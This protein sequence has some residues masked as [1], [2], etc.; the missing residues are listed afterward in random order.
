MAALGTLTVRL[1]RYTVA[2]WL[3]LE[4]EAGVRSTGELGD[5]MVVALL[6]AA[7]FTVLIMIMDGVVDEPGPQQV[8]MVLAVPGAVLLTVP[9]SD[10]L[11]LPFEVSGWWGVVLAS[12]AVTVLAFQ[13]GRVPQTMLNGYPV[14]PP[15]T[16]FGWFALA[17]A[18]LWL[19]QAVLGGVRLPGTVGEQ[20][21]TLAV[22]AGLFR[23]GGG[24]VVYFTNAYGLW[25]IVPSVVT[26]FVVCGLKL[27]A[28]CWL[29]TWM[30]ATLRITGL[31][32]FALATLMVTVVTA[33]AWWYEQV[34]REEAMIEEQYQQQLAQQQA[35]RATTT[36]ALDAARTASRLAEEK[37]RRQW[38]G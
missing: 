29:S 37:R 3:V 38:Y 16:L 7:V 4:A 26:P 34:S 36:W 1:L 2:V 20:L 18:G 8:V 13:A 28:L 24:N 11:G 9:V 35:V 25:R 17:F 19:A 33:P 6:V 21:A 14:G 5:R 22:L 31:G 27:W 10:V 23:I 15:A 12:A 30:A 32:T